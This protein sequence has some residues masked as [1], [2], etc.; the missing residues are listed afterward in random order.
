[1]HRDRRCVTPGAILNLSV[2][3][4]P[5]RID[6]WHCID[7]LSVDWLVWHLN[8]IKL[9]LNRYL[10][11]IHIGA[12][13][14]VLPRRR[15]IE[16]WTGEDL[17]IY[18]TICSCW[19]SDLLFLIYIHMHIFWTFEPLVLCDWQARW[20]VCL[21]GILLSIFEDILLIFWGS[22]APSVTLVEERVITCQVS[23]D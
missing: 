21:C 13:R 9:L 17:A 16:L 15:C 1:M 23:V 11:L 6:I 5:S 10:S 12:A 18:I 4:A 7:Y 8:D 22:I 14:W 3:D 2:H 20:R 19:W